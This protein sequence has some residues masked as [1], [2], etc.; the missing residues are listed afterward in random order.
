MINKT[1]AFTIA[2]YGYRLVDNDG[3]EYTI[4]SAHDSC[5]TIEKGIHVLCVYFD[6]IGKDYFVLA[7]G[8]SMLVEEIEPGRTIITD[9]EIGD[10]ESPKFEFDHGNVKLIAAIKA[11]AANEVIDDIA[12]LPLAVVN[13]FNQ[14]HFAHLLP[15]GSW[16]PKKTTHESLQ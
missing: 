10:D 3:K 15:K 12:Y 9:L 11:I 4:Q 1:T 5:L 2:G 8:L 6:Q 7:H 14:A 13:L 16:K